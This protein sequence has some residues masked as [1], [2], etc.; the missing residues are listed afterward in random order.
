VTL[1]EKAM[2]IDRDALIAELRGFLE[3]DYEDFMSREEI[4][5]LAEYQ[6]GRI[7]AL[8]RPAD[9]VTLT[10]DEADFLVGELDD[11]LEAYGDSDDPDERAANKRR[12]ALLERLQG[13]S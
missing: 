9:G 7:L 2:G 12:Q 6:A 10:Y 11:M 8:E 3:E 13:A 5:A 1:E 4:T